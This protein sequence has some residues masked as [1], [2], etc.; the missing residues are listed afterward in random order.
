MLSAS[1]QIGSGFLETSFA[2]GIALEPHVIGCDAGSTDAGPYY[3]GA[4]KPHFPRAGVKRDMR[5]MMLGRQQVG[6]PLII[7][8]CGFAGG[9]AGVDWMVDIVQEIARDEGLTVRLATIRSEQDKA[10]LKRCLRDGR[11]T[12]LH[13]A[14]PI[15][16]EVIDRSAHIVGMMG[17]API[18][19]AIDLGAEIVLCGR[20]TDTSLFAVVPLM[21]GAGAGPA[22]HAAKILE[23][24]TA[25][26][27]IRRRPDS[28]MAWVRDD[29]FDI[30]P[31]DPDS[32]CSPQ[33]VASHTL[34]ENADPFLI[35][36][37]D[38]TIDC[39]ASRY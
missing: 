35:T 29:H 32:Q 11:I 2:R 25:A 10:Y 38:G 4:G 24:G 5:L 34:Y 21:R 1:G 20:A 19:H 9:D 14:P 30:E 15:S 12:A 6:V 28:I 23:C 17:H 3:L 33:S 27:V 26:T 37:P 36:E 7:G 31:M 13:P 39:R 8:S 16:E 18:A 22:W